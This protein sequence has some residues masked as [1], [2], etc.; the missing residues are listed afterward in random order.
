[1]YKSAAVILKEDLT[2]LEKQMICDKVVS[3]FRDAEI[4]DVA[5]VLAPML[6]AR[7][8]LQ[9]VVLRELITFFTSQMGMEIID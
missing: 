3:A 7:G 8:D 5:S 1:M 2:D 4:N 9:M 6:L